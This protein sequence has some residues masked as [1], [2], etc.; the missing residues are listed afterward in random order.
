MRFTGHALVRCIERLQPGIPGADEIAW[1]AA[2]LEQ[3][4]RRRRLTGPEAYRLRAGHAW[5]HEHVGPHIKE[6]ILLEGFWATRRP[7]WC[8]SPT[9]ADGHLQVGELCYFPVAIGDEW[10]KLTTC[11]VAKDR[12]GRDIDWDTALDRGYTLVPKPY[13]VR[14]P[15]LLSAPP[16]VTV[17][18]WAWSWRGEHHGFLRAFRATRTAARDYTQQENERRKAAVQAAYAHW[19]SQCEV[20]MQAFRAR[21]RS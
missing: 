5:L 9:P 3:A 1:E 7:G 11:E 19:Y 4:G 8:P 20:A 2:R 21:H 13:V 15:V 6:L 17:V 14:A 10:A 18:R 12:A 16:L